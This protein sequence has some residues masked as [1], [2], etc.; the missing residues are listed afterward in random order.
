H[1]QS[2]L[3]ATTPANDSWQS[4]AHRL[5]LD[6]TH[7]ASA[8]MVEGGATLAS[9]RG[10]FHAPSGPVPA[11]KPVWSDSI[12]TQEYNLLGRWTERHDSGSVLQVQS[13]LHYRHNHDLVN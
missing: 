4:Q 11:V 10:L 13:Y 2:R 1:G 8:L 5:R 12:S 6:W 3:D 9:L 7:N